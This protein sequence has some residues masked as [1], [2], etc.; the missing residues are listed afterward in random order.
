MD[1][2]DEARPPRLLVALLAFL[3]LVVLATAGVLVHDRTSEAAE[4]GAE[5]PA[6]IGLAGWQ[7]DDAGRAVVAARRAATRY[8]SLDHRHVRRDLR[9]MRA[10][11]T[12]GFVER[13]DAQSE[14]VARR[15]R[16]DRLQ[17][18][19]ALPDDGTAT[20]YLDPARARVLVAVDVTIR[21]SAGER[22]TRYRT[23]VALDR[24]DGDWL[25]AALDEVA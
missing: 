23:R 4:V 9:R 14:A 18:V 22:T 10:L 2:G 21:S 24:V 16:R 20:E 3:L 17:L 1:D 25:V 13:F 15:V 7:D 8:F 19:P 5:R 6:D 11:G 12:A